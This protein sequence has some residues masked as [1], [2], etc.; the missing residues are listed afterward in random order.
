VNRRGPRAR[1]ARR[2]PFA[3]ER[4][5]PRLLLANFAVTNTGEFGV[6]SLGQAIL[7][8]NTSGSST[9]SPANTITFHIPGTGPQ[10]IHLSVPLPATMKPVLID[11]WSQGGPGYTGPPLI[12]LNGGRRDTGPF[13]GLV[14]A[15][16]N[17]TV[18]GLAI[19]GFDKAQLALVT[20]GGDLIQGDYLGTD[21]TGTKSGGGTGPGLAIANIARNTIGGSTAAA[22]NLIS[23]NG[24]DGIDIT[25]L[26]ATANLIVGN[27]VG[28]NAAGTAALTNSARS[29]AGAGISV[30]ASASAN[31]IGGLGAGTANLVSGNRFDGI[32]IS[33]PGTSSNVVLGNL[34]GTDKSGTSALGN[35]ASGGAP[36]IA[37]TASAGSNT[38]GATSSAGRN[39]ISG[40]VN[41][42]VSITG[43]GTAGNVVVGNDIGTNLAGTAALPNATGSNSAAVI[44]GAGASGNT[45]GGRRSTDR[46]VISGNSGAGVAL[47]GTTTGRNLV[48]GNFIGTN[49]SGTAALANGR[50][51]VSGDGVDVFGT[52]SNNTIGGLTADR[53]NVISGNPGNG[54]L[55]SATGTSGNLVAGNL[56]GT[57]AGGTAAIPNAIGV[58]LF[59]GATAN[60]VGGLTP[61]ARNLI[62]GN[63][64]LG[65][66]VIDSGTSGNVVR[67]NLIGTGIK[68]QGPLPNPIG[69]A[70]Y[71]GASGNVIGGT[72]SGARN[73]V[74]GNT[75]VGVTVIGPGTAGNAVRG[76]FIGTDVTGTR[77]LANG[78]AS[79]GPG[80]SLFNG[81]V[82]N[83]IGGTTAGAGNLISGNAA[84]GV[85]I[86]G[87][88]TAGNRLLGNLIGTNLNGSAPL[89]NG[90]ASA[91]ASG[92]AIYG[93]ASGNTVG[94]T[95]AGARNVLS[96][97][98]KD[99]VGLSGPGTS[100]NVV[101]GNLIG[102][103]INGT[104]PLGN[105]VGAA[106]FG[107]A[108][109]NTIG[110]TAPGARNVV[111][112][113]I[114][115]GV[116]LIGSGTASNVVAGNFVGTDA[117]GNV[118]LRNGGSGNFPGVG[119]YAGAAANTIGGNVAGAGNV[120]SGN[121]GDGLD[122]SGAGSNTNVA[123]GNLIGTNA[124]GSAALANGSG[125]VFGFGVDVYGGASG[126][127]IGGTLP[128]S[129]NVISASPVSGVRLA[130]AGTTG[131][132]VQQN[133]IGTDASGTRPLPNAQSGVFV[134]GASGNLIGGQ[135]AGAGNTIA[136]S[137]STAIYI[138]SAQHVSVLGNSIFAN[139][140]PGIRLDGNANGRARAPEIQ[141]TQ[142]G[143]RVMVIGRVAGPPG[144][145]FDVELFTNPAA[146]AAFPPQGRTFLT[147][148][149][150]TARTTFTV[151]ISGSFPPGTFITATATSAS[152]DTSAFST[153]R[154]IPSGGSTGPARRR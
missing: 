61:G 35:G 152:G 121:S 62:S 27:Y 60:S 22:R 111:S 131:N 17:S 16:G 54:V 113:N 57:N 105:V 112:G 39:L 82:G 75:N 30:S 33:G 136:F 119:I 28:T 93:G 11:G 143:G 108:S 154:V 6:G 100:G 41:A 102:T 91:P 8:L 137:P 40:N 109:G 65:V 153:G 115:Q 44:I 146:D 125:G 74:S 9:G 50:G 150:A 116:L 31:Q 15:G 138:T 104:Q 129:G 86:S 42:A 73:I 80:I 81:A 140:G 64:D 49:P 107:G 48:A 84:D 70:I 94:G 110:G 103:A 10:V 122:I 106:V 79:G 47:F 132:A 12:V 96:G 141:I 149:S 67:G 72:L 142:R 25:G 34:I 92:V 68:G 117:T 46:N 118:V 43:T 32:L 55:I 2:G 144:T 101:L 69:I 58:V 151:P 77:A 29:K 36:G 147:R 120:I 97:N 90:S 26:G 76:N 66:A 56:I 127:T 133:R 134:D 130:G 123:A 19:E 78:S 88:G 87:A 38:I 45:V 85:R 1:T 145:R 148:V 95:S 51:G 3:C 71:S 83:T 24:A 99:G 21:V 126:N 124:A 135:P 128:G 13:E 5:E 18:Q 59:H 4:L 89:P 63:T 139:R 114:E 53:G 98:T 7:D 20:A 52:A 14:V 37:I 23:G